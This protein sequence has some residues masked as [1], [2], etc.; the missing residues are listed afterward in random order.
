MRKKWDYSIVEHNQ[1]YEKKHPQL[2]TVYFQYKGPV[3]FENR[4]LFLKRY[5]FD[6]KDATYYYQSSLPT[7]TVHPKED[8][9]TT[10]MV[11]GFHKFEK[12]PDN[13]LKLT[14]ILQMEDPLIVQFPV[15]VDTLL[16]TTVTTWYSELNAFFQ[17]TELYIENTEKEN[18]LSQVERVSYEPKG[19]MER[20][21]VERVERKSYYAKSPRP[22]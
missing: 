19:N 6:H 13:R 11:M 16:P 20:F 12:L 17:H 2:E 21:T 5:W 3:N 7:E 8:L 1:L 9:T 15:M 22:Q 10:F 14:I 4:E 18:Q